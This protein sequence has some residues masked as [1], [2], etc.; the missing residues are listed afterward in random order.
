MTPRIDMLAFDILDT[1]DEIHKVIEGS[2][3][4]RIPVYE[5]SI[6]NIIGILYLNHYYRRAI[7]T[8]VLSADDIRSLLM[9]PCFL[10]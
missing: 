3:F 10:H 8:P 6:D 5:D 2:H 4:S 1:P 7:D 9:E